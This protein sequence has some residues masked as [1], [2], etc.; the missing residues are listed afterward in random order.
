MSPLD[1]LCLLNM[2]RE[3][4][5]LSAT[6]YLDTGDTLMQTGKGEAILWVGP[7][8]NELSQIPSLGAHQERGDTYG[9]GLSKGRAWANIRFTGS[10]SSC[11]NNDLSAVQ[12][13]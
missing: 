13:S 4:I 3:Q 11:G 7:K 12:P 2:A 6:T 5:L 1:H 8:T 10:S 9:I